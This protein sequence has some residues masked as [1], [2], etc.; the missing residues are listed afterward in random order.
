L[1]SVRDGGKTDLLLAGCF[2]FAAVMVKNDGILFAMVAFA[3][4]L[5]SCGWRKWKQIILFAVP[6]LGY[7]P[8]LWWMRVQLKLG[9]HAAEG[10]SADKGTLIYGWERLKPAVFKALEIWGDLQQWSV[11]LCLIL[12]GVVLLLVRGNKRIR[13]DLGFPVVMIGIFFALEVFHSGSLQWQMGASW[14]RLTIQALPL[15]VM[16]IGIWMGRL[17]RQ[18]SGH[19]V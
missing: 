15:L 7:L 2:A 10:I 1:L 11:V 16:V 3:W 12:A 6:L 9:T 5:A 4:L 13:I 8:W 18:G 19:A 17:D 14:D